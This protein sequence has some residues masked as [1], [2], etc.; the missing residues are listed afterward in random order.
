M[1]EGTFPEINGDASLSIATIEY[2][3]PYKAL[4]KHIFS[5]TS[6][7]VI[8]GYHTF[9]FMPDITDR[10]AHALVNS[11]KEENLIEFAEKEGFKLKNRFIYQ[12]NKIS[13]LPIFIF[14]S[15]QK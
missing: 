7:M 1:N 12:F 6:K 9:E 4:L 3:N 13:S 8:I 2:I 10:K 14:V 15:E 11:L 5:H